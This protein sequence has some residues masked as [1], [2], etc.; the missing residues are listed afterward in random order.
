LRS[1]PV[2]LRSGGAVDH[3][4]DS[5]AGAADVN[6]DGYADILVGDPISDGSD[7]VGKAYLFLGGPSGPAM[8]SVTLEGADNKGAT[9]GDYFGYSLAGAGDIDR[10]GHSDIVVGAFSSHSSA[11]RAYI[12]A[13]TG[14]GA[15]LV[16][17]VVLDSPTGASAV[18]GYCVAMNRSG[19]ACDMESL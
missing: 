9:G 14:T 17:A 2:V 7:L 5:V 3:F 8:P 18:F 4:G 11:G 19:A 15:S 16:P 12:F 6:A 13:G 10:D 1:A